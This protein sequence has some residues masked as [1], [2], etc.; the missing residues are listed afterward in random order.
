MV[1]AGPNVTLPI[2]IPV[3]GIVVAVYVTLG[4]VIDVASAKETAAGLFPL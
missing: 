1:A 4:L 3:T 2:G